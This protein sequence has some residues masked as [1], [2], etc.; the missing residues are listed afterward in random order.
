MLLRA[1]VLFVVAGLAAC[2][3]PPAAP[4]PWAAELDAVL[5]E[6]AE[7]TGAPSMVVGVFQDGELV[8]D[9]AWGLADRDPAVAARADVAYEIGSLSKHFTAVALLQQVEA[10]AVSLDDR[11]DDHLAN[12]PPAWRAVTL[13]QLLSHTSG[14]PDYEAAATYT[15]YEAPATSAEILAI[16]ADRPMDFAPGSAYSY[17]NTG[18]YLL[19]LVLEKVTGRSTSEYF[20]DDLFG[21]AGMTTAG[22]GHPAGAYTAQGHKPQGYDNAAET[23][24]ETPPIFPRTTLGAG[25]VALTL[26]DWAKWERALSAGALVSEESLAMTYS[27]SRLDDGTEIRYGLGMVIAPRRGETRYTHSGQTSGYTTFLE[28]YPDR[29]LAML[30]MTNRY[31]GRVGGVATTLALTVM[32][33]LRYADWPALDGPDPAETARARRALRQ[34]V[35]AEEPL[36]LLSQ[37]LKN[38]AVG[39]G[40]ADMRQEVQPSVRELDALVLISAEDDGGGRRLVYRGGYGGEV[41]FWEMRFVDGIL[42]GLNWVE[43]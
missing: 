22:L 19:C 34:A 16:V 11:L 27:R 35:L 7:A 18:Y 30:V 8:Y 38:F 14:V 10:G 32:P 4:P 40:F 29:G 20:E 17:S 42:T 28:R 12:L 36:D 31:G 24:V 41:R 37:G 33:D 43:E 25:A 9:F 26:A 21:P 6:A 5:P 39:E 2:Q 13:R 1:L 23:L 15:V 3:T